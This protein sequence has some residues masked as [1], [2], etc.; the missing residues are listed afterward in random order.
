MR[1]SFFSRPPRRL[2]WKTE[3]FI[4]THAKRASC[5]FGFGSDTGGFTH[6]LHILLGVGHQ[7]VELQA[8][9]LGHRQFGV[10][11][12]ALAA[13]FLLQSKHRLRARQRIERHAPLHHLD[14]VVGV[15]ATQLGQGQRE[16]VLFDALGRLVGRKALHAGVDAGTYRA[17]PKS[18]ITALLSSVMKMLAGLISRCSILCWCTM[19]SPRSTSS[20]SERMVDSRKTFCVFRSRAVMMKSCRVAPSR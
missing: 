9:L 4:A 20:N 13:E 1:S 8:H 12:L 18:I 17:A 5:S 11:A 7:G 14:E 16:A 10:A 6:L 2:I 15:H 19:R 3:N